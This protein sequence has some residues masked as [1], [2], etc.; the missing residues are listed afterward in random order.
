MAEMTPLPDTIQYPVDEAYARGIQNMGQNGP[1]VSVAQWMQAVA[2][3][4]GSAGLMRGG[5]GQFPKAMAETKTIP[6]GAMPYAEQAFPVSLRVRVHFP[7][8]AGRGADVFEDA[9]K[10]LNAGH[11]MARARSNWP[12]AII[13]SLGME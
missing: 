11:A 1:P 5:L 3:A 12:G 4:L 2:Q 6:I 7:A 10:G 9:V 13:E 8:E